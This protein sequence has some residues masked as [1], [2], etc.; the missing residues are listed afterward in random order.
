MAPPHPATLDEDTLAA[1]C[2][3]RFTRRSG[4]GGQHRNKVET[5]VI[6]SHLPTG[7]SAEAH[8][9]RSQSENRRMALRRLRFKLAVDHRSDR[10][11]SP[12]TLWL[13]RRQGQR[14][15]VSDEHAD[16]PS[17]I[18]EAL[19]VLAQHQFIPAPA[20]EQLGVSSS[21]LIGLL[22]QHPPALAV[23]NSQRAQSN[24]RPLK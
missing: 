4:P 2:E 23:L 6:L 16:L 17:L 3:V 8:E 19:D 10:S 12:S 24:L 7:I 21:Q 18:A 14:I 13:S 5:A 1:A 22:R 15:S 11:S 9:E 20:A